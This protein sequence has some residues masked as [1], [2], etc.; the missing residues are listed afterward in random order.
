V[1]SVVYD[2]LGREVAMLVNEKQTTG[3]YEVEWN[4]SSF[5]RRI[6][7]GVYFYQLSVGKYVETKKMVL[8][9]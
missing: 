5:N 1:N 4:A 2:V 7:S 3:N 8:L 6:P 9:R